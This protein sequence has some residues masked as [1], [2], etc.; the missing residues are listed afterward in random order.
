MTSLSSLM[1]YYY[2]SMYPELKILEDK[3]VSIVDKLKKTI[4]VLIVLGAVLCIFL[5]QAFFDK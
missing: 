3:R 5:I 2:E 1:D 4:M